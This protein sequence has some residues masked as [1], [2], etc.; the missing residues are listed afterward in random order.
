MIKMTSSLS[1]PGQGIHRWR[2]PGDL[3]I[4]DV[5]GTF[6]IAWGLSLVWPGP[7]LWLWILLAFLAGIVA[8]RLF[9]VRTRVDRLL[10]RR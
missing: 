4:V 8:H 7:G 6:V 1:E 3:A 2:M 10:F 9:A 5:L